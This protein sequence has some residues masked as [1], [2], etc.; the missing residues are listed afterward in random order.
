[1]RLL[2]FMLK[3]L[4][5]WI[6]GALYRW[7]LSERGWRPHKLR[8]CG[9]QLKSHCWKASLSESWVA[10]SFGLLGF[11]SL[12]GQHNV[13]ETARAVLAVPAALPLFSARAS[14]AVSKHTEIFIPGGRVVEEWTT[15]PETNS[16]R[17][18][19][20]HAPDASIRGG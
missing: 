16:K 13:T 2:V 10:C 1:M 9:S 3:A 14:R 19:R 18:L 12:T 8:S 20:R 6:F 4:S 5:S 15:F 17:W 7:W 11:P